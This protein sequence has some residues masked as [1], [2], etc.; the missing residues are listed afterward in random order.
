MALSLSLVTLLF[1]NVNMKN[2]LVYDFKSLAQLAHALY[3][4]TNVRVSMGLA[5]LRKVLGSALRTNAMQHKWVIMYGAERTGIDT[6]TSIIL[7]H[8]YY[9]K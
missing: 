6:F 2:V 4:C 8:Q 3:K 5:H 9:T 1:D 7:T